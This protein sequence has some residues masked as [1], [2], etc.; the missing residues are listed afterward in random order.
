MPPIYGCPE[1]FRESLAT[2]TATFPEIV[3][4]LL[5][6]SIVLK[7]VQ[8]LKF[9]ALPVP[10]IIWGT[11]KISAVPRYAHAPFSPNLLAFVWMNSVNAQEQFEVHSVSRSRDNRGTVL[12]N[13]GQS[14]NTPT[15][16]DDGGLLWHSRALRSIAR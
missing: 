10:E 3:N 9:V 15:R 8:N 7:Y 16:R 14:L 4:G 12:K 6:R 11:E 2:P 5:L 1:N 13:C